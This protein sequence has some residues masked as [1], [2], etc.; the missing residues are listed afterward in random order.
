MQPTVYFRLIST[1]LLCSMILCFCPLG[2][3]E[4]MMSCSCLESEGRDMIPLTYFLLSFCHVF[5]VILYPVVFLLFLVILCPVVFLP[6][7]FCHFMS[8]CLFAVS[9]LSCHF[10]HFMSCCLFVMSFCS[11]LSFC[12]VVFLLF[13]VILYPVVLLPCLFALA[14]HF[15]QI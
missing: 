3:Q 13:L 9:F 15:S 8:C 1:Q 14:C 11:F 12:P 4:C 2:G 10:C 6:C 7:L 5:F